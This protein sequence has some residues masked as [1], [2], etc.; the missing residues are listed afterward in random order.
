MEPKITSVFKVEPNSAGVQASCGCLAISCD[1]RKA[2]YFEG[3]S[4]HGAQ[5]HS[6]DEVR[7]HAAHR[8]ELLR[9]A[10]SANFQNKARDVFNAARADEEP[11]MR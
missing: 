5:P 1:N 2:E 3:C 7:A 10:A 6:V 11:L 9:V 4:S 8:E